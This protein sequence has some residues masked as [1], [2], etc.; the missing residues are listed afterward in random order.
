MGSDT[1]NKGSLIQ[2][3][4]YVHLST[5]IWKFLIKVTT[6]VPFLFRPSPKGKFWER[7]L[8]FDVALYEMF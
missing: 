4:R 5:A 2:Y 3:V 6:D 8:N 1:E 7:K